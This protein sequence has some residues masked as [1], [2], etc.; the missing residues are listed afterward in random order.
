MEMQNRYPLEY[1]HD[2]KRRTERLVYEEL[3]RSPR[4][5]A[6]IFE[7]YPPGGTEIDFAALVEGAGRYAI[8]AKGGIYILDKGEWYLTEVTGAPTWQR[9]PLRG[10]FDAAMA[11]H[12]HLDAHTPRGD[13][14]FVVPVLALPDLEPGNILEETP[15]KALVVCG[16]AGLLER[17]IERA[18]DRVLHP[19]TAAE[20]GRD[21]SL[22]LPGNQRP[23][24][25]SPST[26]DAGGLDA[27]QVVIQHVD[28]VN[29]YTTPV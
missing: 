1:W 12:R 14:P 13:C 18:A 16:M 17:I 3:A 9:D 25:A 6:V 20:V 5:G 26:G 23:E 28:V 8:S 10:V 19:L 7:A 29:V 4:P 27:R 24:A 22:T 15:G 2:P 21:V 11:W